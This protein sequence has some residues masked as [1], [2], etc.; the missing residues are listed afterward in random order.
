[1]PCWT[2]E[3][4][5]ARY[6]VVIGKF[7]PPHRGHHYLINTAQCQVDHLTVIVCGRAIDDIDA[8]LRGAWLREIHPQA[9]VMVIDDHYPADDSQLWARLTV[10]W[11]GRAPDVVFTSEDYGEVYARYLGCEHVLVDRERRH[12]PCSGTAVRADPFGCWDYLEPSVRAH[13]ARRV[14]VLGAESTGTTTLASALAAHL[15]IPWVPEYGRQYWIEKQARGETL[16]ATSE[17]IHIA[18]EQQRREDTAARSGNQ[19][20]ILDTNAFATYFWHERYVGRPSTEVEQR[21]ARHADLYLLTDV[22]IPFIQDGTRDGEHLRLWMHGRFLEELHGRD[23]RF[24][25]ISGTHSERMVA[26]TEAI[27]RL[28]NERNSERNPLPRSG[29]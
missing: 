23:L 27:D 19:L 3:F 28:V 9:E 5:L 22:D 24:V 12:V 10:E 26:A 29:R 18:E 11:L 1:M 17:F 14:C 21:G 13:Y 7:L 25:V 16:W 15:H 4:P 8:Q 6:G 2:K 20:L